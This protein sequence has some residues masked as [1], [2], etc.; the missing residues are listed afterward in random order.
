MLVSYSAVIG[1]ALD[2]SVW[3]SRNATN[4]GDIH[5]IFCGAQIVKVHIFQMQDD[6]FR[7]GIDIPTIDTVLDS[8][9]VLARNAAY[10]VIASSNAWYMTAGNFSRFSVYSSDSAYSGIASH[11]S[12]KCAIWYCPIIFSGN[13][14]DNGAG[15]LWTY[16]ADNI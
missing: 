13:T 10:I 11:Y 15:A 2:S 16:D 14:A 3:K 4:I 1:A 9:T 7:G 12:R 8:S 6:L 5:G